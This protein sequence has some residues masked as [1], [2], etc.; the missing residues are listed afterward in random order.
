[1]TGSNLRGQHASLSSDVPAC[2]RVTGSNVQSKPCQ[3]VTAVSK[4]C[5]TCSVATPGGSLC[6]A[7]PSQLAPVHASG[8]PNNCKT[9]KGQAGWTGGH[10]QELLAAGLNG[11]YKRRGGVVQLRHALCHL[12]N[13]LRTAPKR[14]THSQNLTH[15]HITVIRYGV[16]C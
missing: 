9:P 8:R 3:R 15:H 1:M 7:N 11:I 4:P 5:K 16:V 12:I 13:P 10:L 2:Q 6:S 14:L